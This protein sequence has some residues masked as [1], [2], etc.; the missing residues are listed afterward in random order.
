MPKWLPQPCCCCAITAR[1][2][3]VSIKDQ[4][5]AGPSGSRGNSKTPVAVSVMAQPLDHALRRDVSRAKFQHRSF[6]RWKKALEKNAELSIKLSSSSP[7]ALSAVDGIAWIVERVLRDATQVSVGGNR[8]SPGRSWRRQQ[9]IAS[10]TRFVECHIASRLLMPAL[11]SI[12]GSS[13]R[14]C[15][16]SRDS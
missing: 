11:L 5:E 9:K 16:A 3:L 2:R 7:D 13:P 12:A 8:L 4:T 1:S 15:R 6:T 10:V 14:T